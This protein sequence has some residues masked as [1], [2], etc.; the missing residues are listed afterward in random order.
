MLY[1]AGVLT[2]VGMT[3]VFGFLGLLVAL[4]HVSARIMERFPGAPE[5]AQIAAP[6]DGAPTGDDAQIAAV[7][8]VVASQRGGN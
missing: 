7:L 1:Q 3:T 2:V 8:A 6:A 5:T 4:M